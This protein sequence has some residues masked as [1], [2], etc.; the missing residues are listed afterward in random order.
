MAHDLELTL[1]LADYRRH[2]AIQQRPRAV[3][4][5]EHKGQFEI[6]CHDVSFITVQ[7]F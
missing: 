3:V 2:F 4:I 7:R 6:V 1:M 5:C